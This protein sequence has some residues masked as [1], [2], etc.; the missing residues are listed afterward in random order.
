MQPNQDQ[1]DA[2]WQ[3]YRKALAEQGLPG[4]AVYWSVKRA[5]NFI[6]SARGL[7]LTEHTA[8]D[9]RARL[10]RQAVDGRLKE[11]QCE[12]MVAALRILFAHIILAEGFQQSPF[13]PN[14]AS[15]HL[16]DHKQ[17]PHHT[18][19]SVFLTCALHADR[20]LFFRRRLAVLE[21]LL[22]SRKWSEERET[23]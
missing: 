14:R 4:E 15:P 1:T 23:E 9:L 11:R 13:H 12:Q 16:H 7:R 22:M 21:S 2:F 5:E 17:S 8:E 20:R 3:R 19:E 18:G 6:R 10:C